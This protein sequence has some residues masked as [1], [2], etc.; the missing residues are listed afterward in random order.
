VSKAMIGAE[1]IKEVIQTEREARDMRGARPAHKFKG[2]VTFDRVTFGY[3]DE[4]PVLKDVSL[5]IKPGQFVALVGP[6]GGGKSTLAGLIARFYDP[7]SGQVMIDGVDTRNFTVKSLRQQISFVLQETLL[8]HAPVWQNIAYGKPEATRDEIIRAAKLAN[9]DEFIERMP[10]GYD[11]VIGER[12]ATLS[13]GQR[14]RIAIARAIIRD[15][16]ILILDEPS[17]GLDAA[18]EELV[19]EAL[20]RLTRDK[21]AIVIAHRLTTVRKA[22]VI[23]VLQDG[24]IVESGAHD[25]LMARSGLYAHLYEIQFSDTAAA[26]VGCG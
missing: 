6:T 13:G 14:Q 21:T 10:Q 2:E 17:S 20:G 5:T 3:E 22:D 9:A 26:G 11:T 15:S 18:S 23:F 25:E 7:Q 1:R 24:V 12:G 4:R 19:F 8:F 16:P